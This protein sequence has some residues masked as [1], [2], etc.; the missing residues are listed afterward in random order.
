M[1]EQIAFI[2]GA[3]SGLGKA[4]AE[5]FAQKGVDLILSGRNQ[6]GL[7]HLQEKLSEKVRVQ[8]IVADLATADGRHSIINALNEQVPNLIINNAGFGLYGRAL[9]YPVEK[10][11][12]ILDVN[13]R[14][15][16]EI[17][18]EA[19]RTLMSAKKKGVILNVSSAAAFQ[20][21][22]NMAIYSATKAFVNQ[23]SQAL[24]FEFKHNGIRVLTICPGMIA[25]RFQS[26]AGGK[27]NRR[28]MGVMPASFVA[29]QIWRQIIELD[30]LRIVD[31]KY[32]FLTFLSFFLSKNLIATIVERNIEKRL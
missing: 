3:T 31:W 16:L 11:L 25:T 32:R 19:G 4:T 22:P 20:I 17:T 29:E 5:L 24:D 9:T 2:T 13:G 27:N 15:A 8:T 21:M 1:G 28:Q 30:S 23:F 18:L 6:Q 26:R 14:A 10:Q 12:E 7:E